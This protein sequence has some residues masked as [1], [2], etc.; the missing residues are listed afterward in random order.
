MLNN[1]IIISLGVVSLATLATK[2]LTTIAITKG[3]NWF[4]NQLFQEKEKPEKIQIFKTELKKLLT[5]EVSENGYS[6]VTVD[7]SPSENLKEIRNKNKISYK[8]FPWFTM[9]EIKG[10]KAYGTVSVPRVQPLVA[11]L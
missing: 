7:F 5:S 10:Q 1:N 8:I 4:I 9:L 6:R 3:T 11:E 2:D